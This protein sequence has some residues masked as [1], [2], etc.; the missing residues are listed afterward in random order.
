VPLRNRVDPYGQLHGDPGRGTLTGNRGILH[1]DFRH[2]VRTH[3]SR[4][5]ITCV[6]DWRGRRRDVMTG[7]TWTELF[8]LDEA[9]ALAAGHRPCAYCRRPHY[10]A[11]VDAWS[12]GNPELAPTTARRA[13]VVDR[14]LHRE[15]RGPG[16]SKRTVPMIAETLPVGAMYGAGG[17]VYLVSAPRWARLWSFAG[18][19]TSEP[20]PDSRVDVLTPVSTMN[21][22]KAGYTADLHPSALI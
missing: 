1:D 13:P 21:A 4:S 17:G 14:A 7:R 18:Y 22:L 15:R 10:R 20:L 8:F 6:L 9:T 2:I 11:F 16:G 19:G 12:T 5:W 3:T